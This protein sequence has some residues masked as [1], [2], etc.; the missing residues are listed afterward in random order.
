MPDRPTL[1]DPTNDRGE[2][3]STPTRPLPACSRLIGTPGGSTTGL[4]GRVP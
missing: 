1:P 3:R 2:A 4:P